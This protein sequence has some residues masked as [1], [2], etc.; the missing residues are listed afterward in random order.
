MYL[1]TFFL[2]K[3]DPENHPRKKWE[4][5]GRGNKNKGSLEKRR[6]GVEETLK[7]GVK[8]RSIT[9]EVVTTL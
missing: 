4:L 9:T 6:E 8:Q 7:S 1:F 2:P 3:S 5:R